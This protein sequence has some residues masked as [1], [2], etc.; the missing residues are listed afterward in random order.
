MKLADALGRLSRKCL[1][2]GMSWR[3]PK[4]SKSVCCRIGSSYI[5]RVQLHVN[6]PFHNFEGISILLKF[7]F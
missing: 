2:F 5:P 4:F 1:L 7:S 3:T 6:L